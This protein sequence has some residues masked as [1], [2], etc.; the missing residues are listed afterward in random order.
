MYIAEE[1]MLAILPVCCCC[2]LLL[3]LCCLW[4]WRRDTDEEDGGDDDG[5]RGQHVH[6]RRKYVGYTTCLLFIFVVISLLSPTCW[7]YG[8]GT[9][10]R[11]MV[12]TT[13]A[14]IVMPVTHTEPDLLEVVEDVGWEDS[15]A[16]DHPSP[17]SAGHPIGQQLA[18]TSPQE[19]RH[20]QLADEDVGTLLRSRELMEKPDTEG[21]SREFCL[22]VQLLDLLT[23]ESGVLYKR[24][25]DN[26]ETTS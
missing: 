13:T 6:C 26:S 9:T 18:L 10:T 4:L 7:Q 3:S 11:K 14:P 2:F 22:L 1:S 5:T 21:R 24:H 16:Q 12:A 23:V 19:L 17:V 15:W 8:G 25:K 20:L